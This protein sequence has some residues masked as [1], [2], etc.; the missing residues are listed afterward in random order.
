MAGETK[1]DRGGSD[2]S[3]RATAWLVQ[4]KD[5]PD[6][7][8]LRMQFFEWLVSNPAHIAAWEETT[9]LSDLLSAAG[10]LP[11]PRLPLPA[12]L[13]RPISFRTFTS[14]KS[15]ESLMLAA[16]LAWVV[17]PNLM[18][19]LRSDRVTGAGETRLARLNDGNTVQLAPGTTIA[20][21]DDAKARTLT[22]LRRLAWFDVVHDNARPLGSLSTQFRMEIPTVLTV[23]RIKNARSQAKAYKLSRAV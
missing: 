11:R 16:C 23:L 5:D 1:L 2:L 7:E 4:M 17:T 22:L 21:A 3:R 15:L 6:N 9:R 14:T 12:A 10:P 18:I 19:W 13:A 20:F 8:A